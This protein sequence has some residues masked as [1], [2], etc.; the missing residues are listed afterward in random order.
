MSVVH[1]LGRPLSA[2][3]AWALAA[4]SAAA[5]EP[6]AARLAHVPLARVKIDDAFWAPKLKTWR[7]VTVA[8]GFDKFEK[9]G[10]LRNFDHVARG[11]LDAPHGG[12]PWYDGLIYEMIRG[13]A[14]LMAQEPAPD[15]E[16]KIDGYIDRI[17][18]A[19]ARDPDGYIN[20][21]T[22]MREPSHRWGQ[23]GG[24]DRQQ[25]D[26][27]NI[28][29]LVEAGVHYERAT[30]KTKL[31][32]TAVRAANG[33]IA[34]MG[35]PPRKNI[36]PGHA[37]GE[38]SFVR[39]YELFRDRPGL[40]K[41][42]GV[43]VDEKGYL[44]LARFWIDA[45][46]HH[47]GRRDF[48]EYG[49]DHLPVLQQA[50]IEGHAVRAVLL[51]SGV[52]AFGVAAD[53]PP[54]IQAADRLWSNMVTRRLYITGGVGAIAKDEKFGGDFVL[55]NDGYLETCAAVGCAFLD[56]NLFL[57][58]GDAPK[59]DELERSLYNG[60]LAGVSLHG[61]AY[62]YENPLE[63]G[64]DR[65]RW[66]W[67]GCPCCPPMFLKLMGALPGAIYA[68][69][70]EGVYVNLFIGSLARIDLG[71]EP[72][73]RLGL[74]QT[75]NYPWE[76]DVRLAV[77]PERPATFDVRIRVPA[78]CRGG[79]MNGGLYT[80]PA[81]GPDAFR[82]AVNGRPV[83]AP[84]IVRGY[85]VI[86]REW[87]AGDAIDVHMDMP[88]RRVAA[89]PRVESDRGRVAL[90]RGPI[91]YCLESPDNQGRVRDLFLPEGKPIAAERRP[92]LLGGVT[93][94][95]AGAGRLPVDGGAPVDVEAVAVPYHAN[96]NRGPA[97]MIVWAPTAPS[98]AQPAT[99]ASLATPTASHCFVGD[100]VDAMN[101]G[102]APKGSSDEK[103]KRFTWWDRRGT[104]EWA[105]YDFGRPR[106]VGSASVY[107]WDDHRLGRHC[108]PPASWR[109][110]FRKPDGSWEPVRVRGEYGT[111][112]DAPNTVEFEPVETTAL[113]IEAKL[114]PGLSAGILQWQVSPAPT[115][116]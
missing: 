57:A 54:Y 72:G 59:V 41:D 43:P 48:A 111:K 34:L 65:A 9:D 16:A 49:Q 13:A 83:A 32:A 39:L 23:D 61:D 90:M 45:R 21:Y 69:D 100:T 66:S 56:D 26:L 68:Q 104:D 2:L 24:D 35:P 17:A 113:R 64:R 92:D 76:G 28:G 73:T 89:D 103:R 71:G 86:H 29:C 70:G 109:M 79:A 44:D 12:P 3:I 114:Q 108:A 4:T 105:Q 30:G 98:G 75:T 101:D 18:A 106:A 20:T 25:H 38:E 93:I 82:V 97:E 96:A 74:V 14:D 80:T 91:V 60:A 37:L 33:M 19:A 107:W 1:R 36:I 51:A 40:K 47:E 27:Y 22:Q 77:D 7:T 115:E 31:L 99:I 95:R 81:A 46:G 78:W 11:E 112:L 62:F 10:A 102:V 87:R 88:T 8:D 110:V 84:P 67:H 55:P 5:A 94:L 58:T 63:A 53:Q 42:L 50:T 15:L 116:R 85:A 6:P 52:A